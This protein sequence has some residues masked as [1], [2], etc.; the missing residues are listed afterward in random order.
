[1]CALVLALPAVSCGRQDGVGTVQQFES[2]LALRPGGVLDV[3]ETLTIPAGAGRGRLIHRGVADRHDGVSSVSAMVDGRAPVAGDGPGQ[4]AINAGRAL[5][6]TWVPPGSS[7]PAVL[8]LGYQASGT[9][10]VAGLRGTFAW[11]ALSPGRTFSIQS[12]RVTLI[13]P[14]GTT[15]VSDIRMEEPGWALT[16]T[17]DRA[18]AE[19]ANVGAEEPATVVVQFVV[20]A[21]SIARPVWQENMERGQLLVPAF[22]S[23]GLFI[24]VVGL[25]ALVMVRLQSPGWSVQERETARKGLRG[26][27]L[28]IMVFGAL[29]AL[30]F[31]VFFGQFGRAPMAIPISIMVVG[32]ML[33]ASPGFVVGQGPKAQGQSGI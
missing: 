8:S 4:V 31:P 6:V 21:G 1:V 19:K 15:T 17:D 25:G 27:G 23:A 3:E 16:R 28:A 22:I 12:A 10:H 30:V 9:V 29:A 33:A 32:L 20:E 7:A 26:G 18:V 5:D 14:A 2:R 11:R 13:L 24:L